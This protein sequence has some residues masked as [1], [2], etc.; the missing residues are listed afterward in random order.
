M[1]DLRN[2][3]SNPRELSPAALAFIGD[4]VFELLARELVLKNG[5]IPAHKMHRLA[6]Q[7][8]CAK[9]QAKAFSQLLPVL[10]EEEMRILKRGRNA[11]SA[12]V[13]KNCSVM[14]YRKATAVEALFGY[15]YLKGEIPRMIELF[16]MIEDSREAK[17]AEERKIKLQGDSP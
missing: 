2:S 14:E 13:P 17:H 5:T 4:G 16:G 7:K 15:L 9:A 10:N 11:N 6:V 3:E 8:V 12:H 1:Q